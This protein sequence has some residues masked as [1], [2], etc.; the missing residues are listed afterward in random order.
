MSQKK[1]IIAF[2]I[3]FKSNNSEG[4]EDLWLARSP[5]DRV[6]RVR[7]LVGDIVL[8]SWERH[9]TLTMFTASLKFCFIKGS[10]AE[11][12]CFLIFFN[13]MVYFVFFFFCFS[14]FPAS[15]SLSVFH[16]LRCNIF[17]DFL[18]SPLF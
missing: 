10:G 16:S 18:A 1:K 11:Q 2:H 13:P 12:T 8:C 3:N 5:P 15:R 17:C 9:V 7:A 6:V 14:P 4:A